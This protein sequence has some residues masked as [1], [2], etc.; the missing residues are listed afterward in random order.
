MRL[1]RIHLLLLI[2]IALSTG[3]ASTQEEAAPGEVGRIVA[4]DSGQYRDISADE[5]KAIMDSEESFLVDTHVPNEGL[6]PQIDAR[7][8]YNEI[9][10]QLDK[11]PPD[12]GAKIVLTCKSGGM[13]SAAAR[14]LADIGYTNVYNLEGGFLAWKDKGYPFTPEP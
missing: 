7:I 1:L 5:L 10:Q 13:S 6:M 4:T 8:P 14:D 3:C 11:L 9:L 12:K 2:V